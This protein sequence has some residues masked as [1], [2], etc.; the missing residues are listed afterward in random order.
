M[1][2]YGYIC[3]HGQVK[4]LFETCRYSNQTHF[5]PKFYSNRQSINNSPSDLI[6]IGKLVSF[7]THFRNQSTVETR[8][9][10]YDLRRMCSQGIVRRNTS[11]SSITRNYHPLRKRKKLISFCRAKIWPWNII[12]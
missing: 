6:I 7:E 4:R 9:H 10:F 2:S 8:S 12:F 3:L 1:T 11:I 5:F